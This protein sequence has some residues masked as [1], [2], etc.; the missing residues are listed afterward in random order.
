MFFLIGESMTNFSK[1]T[2]IE[3]GLKVLAALG[4]ANLTIKGLTQRLGVTKGSF[5]HHF[6]NRIGFIKEMLEH[7]ENQ[8]T[9]DIIESSRMGKT[10]RE[11]NEKLVSHLEK[12]KNSELEIAIRA[13][14]LHDKT[15]QKFQERVD[16]KRITYLKDL[17]TI[18]TDDSEKADVLSNIQYLF[19]IGNQQI[20]SHFSE[21]KFKYY[22]DA[23]NN[24][25]K[26]T[27]ESQ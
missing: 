23:L 8:M 27:I 25:F 12:T 13:W 17:F 3:E 4:A 2:W 15:V 26:M 19:Y 1:T 11:K 16:K 9:S 14:S 6:K 24:M 22:A 10:F 20:G 18:M 5:Y 7:W 21:E